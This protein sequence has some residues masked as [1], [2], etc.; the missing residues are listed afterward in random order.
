MS[1]AKVDQRK[2]AKKNVKKEVKKE[3]CIRA[4]YSC[5][6]I[7][8]LCALLCWAGFSIYKGVTANKEATLEH[9]TADTN[10]ITDYLNELGGFTE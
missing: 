8:I 7:L 6:G 3:K 5:A 1:Q 2:A 10:A 4:I 9:I